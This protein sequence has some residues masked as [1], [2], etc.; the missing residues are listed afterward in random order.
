MTPSRTSVRPMCLGNDEEGRHID[1][2]ADRR[3]AHAGN[4]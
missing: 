1:G 4:W 3:R 2:D